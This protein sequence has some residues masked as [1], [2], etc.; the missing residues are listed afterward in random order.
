MCLLACKNFLLK[1][2][3]VF[4]VVFLRIQV[5]VA[6]WSTFGK[7]LLARLTICSLCILTFCDFSYFL[8]WF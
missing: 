5:L 3:G 6:K 2:T 4:V 7:E 8:F 1:N